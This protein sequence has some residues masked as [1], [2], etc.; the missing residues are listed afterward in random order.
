MVPQVAPL[1]SVRLLTS[2]ISVPL[3]V[4][5]IILVLTQFCGPRKPIISVLL[6]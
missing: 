4:L 1:T 5:I 2:A 3:L 6:L